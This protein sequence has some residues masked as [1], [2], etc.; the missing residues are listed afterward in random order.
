[1]NILNKNT[2]F[3]YYCLVALGTILLL[4]SINSKYKELLAEKK[5]EQYYITKIVASD[6]DALLFKYE[7]MMDLISDDFLVN[8]SLN[9][10]MIKNILQKSE[11]L[12]GVTIYN[13]DGTLNSKSSN[14]PDDPR[15]NLKP[16]EQGYTWFQN[17][18]LQS[19]MMLNK[20]TYSSIL[21]KW[22]IPIQKRLQDK[23]GNIIGIIASSIDIKK[24][25]QKWPN[26]KA[27]GNSIELTLD[28]NF[29]QLLHTGTDIESHQKIYNNPLTFGQINQTKSQLEKQ[30]LTLQTLRDNDIVAQLILS[31]E[32]KK[33]LHTLTYSKHHQFWANSSRPLSD[34]SKPLLYA[35]AY[36]LLF[37]ILITTSTFFLF[38]WIVKVE[39]SKLSELAYKGEHDDLTGCYNRSVLP[40]AVENLKKLQRSFSLLYIDLDNFKN[41]NDSFGHQYG[42]ILLQAVSQRIRNNLGKLPGKI[43]RYSGDEFIVLLETNNKKMVEHFATLLLVNLAKQHLIKNSSFSVTGSIGITRYPNDST[44]LDTLISYAENSM[45]IAKKIKNQYLFFSQAVHEKLIKEAQIEQA[46]H[47]AIDANEISIVY[48]PQLNRQQHLYGVEALV[49]WHSKELGF[50]PPDQFIPI[51]ETNGLMPKLGQYIMN[52]AMR[53]ISILQEQL[54]INFSLSINVSARQFVQIN[55]FELLMDSINNFGSKSL[56]ITLEITESLFIESLDV[57]LPIFNKMKKNNISLALDDF[58]TGYSSLSMLKNAP[59]DELKIDRSFV[60][61]IT[62]NGKDQ[63]MV[64]SIIEIGKNLNMRVLAEGVET[65]QHVKILEDS[66]CDLFQGYYF[67]HPLKIDELSE[68]IKQNFEKTSVK[69]N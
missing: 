21:K 29:Y 45:A 59:I 13:K 5:H 58:G 49:R 20:P 51:A 2:W 40:Q 11:L 18:L 17:G 15:Y 56:T 66:G 68:F 50:I 60:D 53:E 39:E 30:N 24:L 10:S 8:R 64:K 36:Y 33:V 43:I 69:I 65:A 31:I 32:G 27:F 47:N 67:S 37:Y 44:S 4:T 35:T 22:I 55:F 57:L 54:A 12:I 7:T 34:I 1:M 26:S 23:N 42:D 19:T 9:Q 52:T 6:I 16:E 3:I 46:L 62:S 48:Q 38:K 63:A 28:N 61:Q 14:L 25:E 41:I